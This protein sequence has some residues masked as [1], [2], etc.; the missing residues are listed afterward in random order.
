MIDRWQPGAGGTT[1]LVV[2][3]RAEHRASL[4]AALEAE[5][6]RVLATESARA[7][8][9]LLEAEAAAVL[10]VE[11]C[12]WAAYGD[13][14]ARRLRER[15]AAAQVVVAAADRESAPPRELLRGLGLH[16][17]HAAAD[18]PERLLVL[19]DAA[20][21]SHRELTCVQLAERLKTELLGSVSHE[22]R[23][24]LNVIVGYVDLLRDGAFGACDPETRPVFDKLRGNAAYLLELAEEFLDLSRLEADT[25]PGRRETVDPVPLLRELADW[26]TLLVRDRPVAFEA[27]IPPDLPALAAESAKLRIVVQNLLSNAAKFT[28][29]GRIRLTAAA[30]V[31]GR[32]AIRVS[33]TGPGIAPEHHEA[34][35]DMF[36][37]LRPAG[38]QRKGVGLGLALARRFARLMG[39]DIT[40]ESALGRGATFSVVLPVAAGT[41][42]APAGHAA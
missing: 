28:G 39:G 37:Q 40:V 38:G 9:G 31:D 30:L 2:S 32:V 41:P 42:A 13:A 10:I 34:V 23:T 16:G 15:D 3:E 14:L 4:R 26:F 21:E 17:Y 7:G 36:R 24:P 33:D 8:L 35:F 5:G 1:L 18:G 29:E 11:Q 19:V 25:V 20:L 22:F 6:H 27:D 12:L